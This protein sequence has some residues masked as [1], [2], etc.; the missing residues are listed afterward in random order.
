MLNAGKVYELGGDQAFTVAELAAEI[1]AAAG[2]TIAYNDLPAPEYVAMLASVG[3][4]APFA[5]ILADSD[6]GLARGEL[7]VEGNDLS[8]LLGRPTTTLRDAVRSAL[9]AA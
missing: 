3:V 1:S 4:P 2:T 6:L 7:L 9:P 8:T 5:E